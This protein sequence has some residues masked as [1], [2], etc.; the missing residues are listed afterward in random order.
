[1]K[2]TV[3]YHIIK[4][5]LSVAVVVGLCLIFR[6]NYQEILGTVTGY[7]I[8]LIGTEIIESAVLLRE[9][10][11]KLQNKG[12][13]YDV[14]FYRRRLDIGEHYLYIW[15]EPIVY[16]GDP[17][18]TVEDSP[19]KRFELDPILQFNFGAIMQAHRASFIS[20]PM[21]VRLDDAVKDEN[22]DVKLLTSRTAFYNDL[23]T[24]RSMDYKFND[25]MT[26]R[27]IFENGHYLT[28]LAESKMSNHIGVNAFIFQG[29]AMI[30]AH[31][32]GNAT[33]SK[34]NFTSGLAFGLSEDDIIKAHDP[35]NKNEY[36][37][38]D[39]VFTADDMFVNVILS[40]LADVFDI[41]RGYVCDEYRAGKIKICHLG[42]GRLI[43]MGGKAQ[44]YFAVV[45][46][47]SF[48]THRENLS[49]GKYADRAKRE[50]IDFNKGMVRA[51]G[52]KLLKDETEHVEISLD[53]KK[54]K[55][56]SAEKSFFIN[57]WH[58]VNRPRIDG[59]PDW[60]YDACTAAETTAQ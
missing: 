36:T 22:G 19:K 8:A 50:R 17:V 53:G 37:E 7:L 33:L 60:V 24:N 55:R 32:G 41:D 27:E 2:H 5:V 28:P 54:A 35:L 6:D 21:M 11:N 15:Y 58:L 14:A 56:G 9:D 42:F 10:K 40:R 47:E 46:D 43:F 16:D 12:F 3:R 30:L 45:L 25:D 13:T 4:I 34:N 20:N 48:K 49:G 39:P 44:F 59:V 57:Y 23:V 29:D 51:S 1:M 26:V 52:I 38:R 18:I 31:R